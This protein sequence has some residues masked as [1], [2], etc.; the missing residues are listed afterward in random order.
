MI[1]SIAL[2]DF[3]VAWKSAVLLF[4]SNRHTVVGE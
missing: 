1:L 2:I 3:S 4:A